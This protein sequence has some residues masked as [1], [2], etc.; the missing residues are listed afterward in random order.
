MDEP[1]QHYI[2]VVKSVMLSIC[3]VV[4]IIISKI[5]VIIACFSDACRCELFQNS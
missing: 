3:P 1:V 5:M 4:T 2:I